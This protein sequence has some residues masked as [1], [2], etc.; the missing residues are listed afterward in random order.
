MP[1]LICWYWI[2]KLEA[3]FLSGD[4][5]EA[6]EAAGK[7]K[8]LL[9]ASAGQIAA[10]DYFYYTALTVS[11]LY[12]TASADEQQAWRELLRAHREQLR[13]WA[14]N[15][16]PTFADKHTLVLAEI[17]RIEKRDADALRLYEEAI[18]SARENGF[19]QNEGAGPRTGG[20]VLP[21]ARSRNRWLRLSPQRAE[22]LRP[23]GRARKSK[24]TRRT[25]P[26]PARGTN[27]R[28]LGRDWPAGRAVGRR[29]CSQSVAGDF[30]VRWSFPS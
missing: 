6:L 2:V 1:A 13:E 12:E 19:V 21:G 11:A 17:A 14:E 28:L 26:A 27:S 30:R 23:L 15:Y 16:P 20:A 3:R 5:A 29:D 10:L 9:Q 25:L 4:Y 8:P 22:L 7:A 18:H 24:A